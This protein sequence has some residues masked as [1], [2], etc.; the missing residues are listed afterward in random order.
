MKTWVL[1][2]WVLLAGCDLGFQPGD[3]SNT[4]TFNAEGGG[5]APTSYEV[6][7]TDH[8]LHFTYLSTMV[9][10]TVCTN[11]MVYGTGWTYK[12]PGDRACIGDT[13]R[14]LESNVPIESL[15]GLSTV[16]CVPG[17]CGNAAAWG[18]Q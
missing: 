3:P 16:V 9:T 14:S 8:I 5:V 13:T 7:V 2:L 15:N 4:C 18:C 11:P 1:S 17:N 10:C 12:L 6:C